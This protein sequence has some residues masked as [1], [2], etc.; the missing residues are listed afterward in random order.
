[1]LQFIIYNHARLKKVKLAR[2]G[3]SEVSLMGVELKINYNV[4]LA[5][6]QARPDPVP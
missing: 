4:P 1:L 6:G 2:L 3:I 5:D